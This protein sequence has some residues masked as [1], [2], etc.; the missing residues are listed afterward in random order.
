MAIITMIIQM[1]LCF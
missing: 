1:Y